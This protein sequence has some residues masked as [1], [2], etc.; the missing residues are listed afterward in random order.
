[1]VTSGDEKVV[2]LRN[3]EGSEKVFRLKPLKNHNELP[4]YRNG[5]G[6]GL[7]GECEGNKRKKLFEHN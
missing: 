3:Y 4:A 7:Q 1:M 2:Q 5:Q 6:R